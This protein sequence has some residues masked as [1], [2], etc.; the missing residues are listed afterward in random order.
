MDA[1]ASARDGVG[2]AGIPREPVAVCG[3][4]ALTARLADIPAAGC[5][6]LPG[7]MA[8]DELRVRQNRV[9]LAVEC[10]GQAERRCGKPN[11]VKRI[12]NSRGDGGNSASLPGEQLC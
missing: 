9:V 4:T 10:Y 12:A 8:G 1:A 3:R 6:A 11:R 7:A 5:I 2:R